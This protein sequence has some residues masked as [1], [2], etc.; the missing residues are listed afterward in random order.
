MNRHVWV[1]ALVCFQL[2][3]TK[4]P[5]SYLERGNR[6]F[7]A[8]KFED[9]E[10]QYRNSVLKDPNFA[11][12]YYRLGLL[13]YT[14]R[15]GAEA[16]RDLQHAADLDPSDERY[17]VELANVSIEAYQVTPGKK[18]LYDQADQEADRL[19]KRDPNSFD[20]LR[21]RGDLLVIDR[22]YD[23]AL[24]EF[25]KANTIRAND[26]NIILS[27]AQILFAQNEDRLGEDLIRQFLNARKDFAPVYDLLAMHYVRAKRIADA[28]HLLELEVASIPKDA[29]PRLLL[30]RSYRDSERYQ[31]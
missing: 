26:P 4:S 11:E 12:G 27:L 30:A 3:C 5:Q 18:K 14:L 21:L 6:L 29:R 24:S 31:E 9:A 17:A 23:E 8:G 25:R 16:L 15:R 1:A 20:G 28:Q 10:L 7:A 22:K 19:L 2:A 13:K